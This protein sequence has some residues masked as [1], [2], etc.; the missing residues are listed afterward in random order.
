VGLSLASPADHAR[1]RR[2]QPLPSSH[3]AAQ[4]PSCGRPCADAG[5]GYLSRAGRN[6]PDA[7]AAFLAVTPFVNRAAEL[8]HLTAI[9]SSKPAPEER[10]P[11]DLVRNAKRAEDAG[12]EFAAISDH[13]CPWLEEQGH[14]PLA[15]SVLGALANATR[16]IGL[17]T[18]VTC[19]IMR[20][21][22]AII[23]QGAATLGLLS[24]NRFKACGPGRRRK[25][26]RHLAQ[27]GMAIRLGS[28]NRF[29][30]H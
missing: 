19:P 25:H 11:A 12:F 7:W 26:T 13:F 3:E 8:L 1:T 30:R 16:R 2:G 20:Y 29:G 18:A 5:G 24:N 6:S 15:W 22:P 14:A 23:V 9:T 10:G 28:Q 17:M 21:H 4:R 27:L